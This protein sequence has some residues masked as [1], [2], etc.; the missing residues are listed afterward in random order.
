MSNSAAGHRTH[1][2]KTLNA[3]RDRKHARSSRELAPDPL[4]AAAL[5]CFPLA[6]KVHSKKQALAPGLSRREGRLAGQPLHGCIRTRL[7]RCP[8]VIRG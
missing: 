5:D 1:S 4:M 7:R 6:L 3:D 2:S 8:I